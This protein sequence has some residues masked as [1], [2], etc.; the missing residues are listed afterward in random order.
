MM[1]SHDDYIT[2]LLAPIH[3][4]DAATLAVRKSTPGG[5]D[6][7]GKSSLKSRKRMPGEI[8]T[9]NTIH[10][11]P[12]P[13][14]TFQGVGYNLGTG[15]PVISSDLKIVKTELYDPDVMEALLRSKDT[16]SKK[17]LLNLS[18]YKR[19]RLHGNAV[20]VVY[21][22]GKEWEKFQFGRLYPHG[23]QGL[24]AF[25]FDMRNPLL[26]KHYWDCDIENAHYIFLSKLAKSWG[27]PTKAIDFYIAN[28]NA[29][30]T[31]LSTNRGIAK[32]AYLKVA[33]GG[34]IKLYDENY[35]DDGLSPEGDA[36]NLKEV[37]AEMT[38]I[39]ERCWLLHPQYHQAVKKKANPKF[40]L[41]S[42]VL[43]NEEKNCLLTMDEYC[44]SVGRQMDVLIHDGGEVR[45]LPDEAKFPEEY[46]RGMEKAIKDKLGYEVNIVVKPFQHNFKMPESTGELI[47]DEYASRIF[48][49]LMG[50]HIARDGDDIFFFNE[51]SGMW[52]NS[53]TSFRTAVV[54][55]KSKLVFT[56]GDKTHNYGG[57]ET[58][59][60]AMRKWIVS[61]LPD[62]HFLAEKSDSSRHKLLFKDG[63]FDFNTG[64]TPGFNPAIVF[65]KRIDRVFPTERNETLI[66]SV[67]KILFEDAFADGDGRD[68][69]QYMKKSLAIGLAGDYRRKKFYMGLGE[70]NCGKGVVVSAFRSTFC[71]Y[72]D[73]W[74]ANNLKYNSRNGQDEAKKL[75]WVKTLAGVRIA[76]SSEFRMDKIPMDGN[77]LKILSSGGDEMK[78]RT[79]NVDQTPHINR[80]TM[81]LLA[82]DLGEITPKDSGTQE[83]IRVIRYRLR[84]VG[85]DDDLA[86]DE[87][88]GDPLI[89]DKFN[90]VAYKDALFWVMADTFRRMTPSERG[91]GGKIPEPKCVLEETK[92]WAGSAD[93][94]FRELIEARFEITGVQTDVV[95]SSAVVEYI[96]DECKQRLSAQKIGRELSKLIP[97][98][99]G[100]DKDIV[101]NGKKHRVG[102]KHR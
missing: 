1:E 94:N 5:A 63:I 43:Q 33:Y 77:L 76:F 64:F 93:N 92:E 39:V 13:T 44:K 102:I 69:G 19:G 66:A 4:P 54:K 55:H 24:Q 57:C 65:N 40:S 38:P 56:E 3:A 50:D 62:T 17:D 74:D 100:V 79:N 20:E 27:L 34:N 14:A 58:K 96:V 11:E 90:T 23:G 78:V 101:K 9:L 30:L 80:T 67:E 26:E 29:C 12:V 99:D 85:K 31:G 48:V 53:E 21:H 88:T 49:G 8:A 83:R 51:E 37:E 10:H 71:G 42:A 25:P 16:F 36:T 59:V 84:F 98:P 2:H 32:T 41:F 35:N 95:E 73:E 22:Y 72:C 15:L 52:D 68:A 6:L 89:K 91:W 47:D 82:N 7:N 28:R 86:P 70:A 18:R 81:W 87:R 60:M 97:L 61:G 75:A 46:L 45:K